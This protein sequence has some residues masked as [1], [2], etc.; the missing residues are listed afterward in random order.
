[1]NETVATATQSRLAALQE[2]AFYRAK[3]SALESGSVG[4]ITKLDRERTSELEKKLAASLSAKSALEAEVAQLESEVEHH[5][6]GKAAAEERGSSAIT[7]A[8][9]VEASYS[10]SLADYAELQRQAHTHQSTLSD[11]LLQVATL[12]A[13]AQRLNA[14]NTHFKERSETSETSLAQHVATLEATQ[15]ALAAATARNEEIQSIWMKTSTELDE[16]RAKVLELQTELDSHK[17]TSTTATTRAVDLERVLKATREEHEATKLLATGSLAELVASH[18][19]AKTREVGNGLD[20]SMSK[21]SEME[22]ES[23]KRLHS[24]SRSKLDETMAE[25]N[26]SRSREVALQ[27][28]MLALRSEVA[29]LR[30]NHAAALVDVGRHK[31][32]AV[33]K[34]VNLREST[35]TRE[36]AEIK[37]VLLRSLMQEHGLSINEEDLASKAVPLDADA[38]PE[39][40]HRRVLELEGRLDQRMRSYTELENAQ[41]ELRKEITESEQRFSEVTRQHQS[42]NEQV[43]QLTGELERAHSSFSSRSLVASPELTERADSAERELESLQGRH[44]HLESTQLKAVQYVKGMEKMLK[45]MKDVRLLSLL[46]ISTH[47]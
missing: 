44:R 42:S 21:A 13:T 26:E 9:A 5:S 20:V 1:M 43:D 19:E 28:Q 31:T 24:E 27:T 35:R 16:S 8:D 29:T 32:F 6:T 47:D 37:S 4:D 15:L 34:D 23:F 22:A 10:R 17:V 7:R 18:R 25:L 11:H 33:N 46:S 12:T 39:Q 3:L 40:L 14:E 38:S 45:R 2:A 36:A 30:D 41:A